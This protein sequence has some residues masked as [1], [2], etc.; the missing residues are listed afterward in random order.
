MCH[1]RDRT[2]QVGLARLVPVGMPRRRHRRND[3]ESDDEDDLFEILNDDFAN[4]S[5]TVNHA[6]SPAAIAQWR[7]VSPGMLGEH[8]HAS[9]HASV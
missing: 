5:T 7:K 3:T 1:L 8:V 2:H 9:V 4:Q 6:W